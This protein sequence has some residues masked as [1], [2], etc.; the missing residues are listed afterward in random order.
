[1]LPNY[2]NYKITTDGKI[3]NITSNMYLKPGIINGYQMIHL[4]NVS[5]G[6]ND[7]LSV[8]RLV[9]AVYIDNP[10]KYAYVNHINGVKTDNR[11]INLEWVSQKMNI[12]HALETGLI[13]PPTR[14]VIKCN[15]DGSEIVRYSS[16]NLAAES[17]GLTRHAI[18]RACLGKNHTAGGYKWKYVSDNYITTP[19]NVLP[20]DGFDGYTVD[21]EGRIY[22]IKYRRHLKPQKNMSG[23]LYVTLCKGGDKKNEYIHRLVA[24]AYIDNP[25]DKQFVNHINMKK[26]DN[27]VGNLEW[28]TQSENSIHFYK[29]KKEKETSCSQAIVEI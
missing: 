1:M 3:L 26:D 5:T 25:D 18:I 2:P 11:M 8:H 22:S 14:G 27:S 24:K 13:T 29:N 12:Q 28:V 23:Y 15:D 20:I 10:S 16:V 4:K 21:K 7:V 19:L 17:I 6:K 9:A